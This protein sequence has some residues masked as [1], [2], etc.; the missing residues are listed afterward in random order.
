M[1]R[2]GVVLVADELRELA[3]DAPTW[4]GGLETIFFALSSGADSRTLPSAGEAV[5]LIPLVSLPVG[6]PLLEALPNLRIVANYGVGTDNIDLAAAA[7]RGVLVT[8]TPG[9]LTAATADLTWALLLAAARRLREGLSLAAAGGWSGW[10]PTQLLGRGL[11]GRLL[12]ILG[13]G[14]IGAAVARR[15]VGFGVR[16]GYWSRRAAP[17]L[18]AETGAKR[19]ETLETLLREADILSI[20]L[21]L[22]TETEGLIGARELAAMKTGA[23]LVNT[24]RGAIVQPAALAAALRSGHLAGAGLD[25]Y[26]EEPGI[27]EELVDLPNA[28]L[29]PHL[30]SATWEARTEM[31]RLAA[32]NVRRVLSGEPPLTPVGTPKS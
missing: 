3:G 19:Y 26:P 28:F 7:R 31:W 11:Q 13:A 27:P 24:A 16:V 23:I 6:E 20:H 10:R 1:R 15:A 32:E 30:G 22:T 2:R 12:G 25:V 17:E 8:N 21:P 9:V 5:G 4:P 18:E 29:L 14:R